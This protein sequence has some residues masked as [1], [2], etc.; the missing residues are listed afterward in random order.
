[1]ELRVEDHPEPIQE[2]RRLVNLHRAYKHMNQGDDFMGA[3]NIEGALQ[4][5]GTAAG[6]APEIEEMP[7]WH[8]VA[9]ADLG[10][11]DEALPIFRQV[12]AKSADWATLVSRLPK[13]GLLRDDP[14]MMEQI[15]AQ[16]V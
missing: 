1:M 8:A 2:L 7:F 5:Y 14:E 12:F 13:S 15:L 6:M 4:E 10:R 9:L 11:M 3:G 16:V